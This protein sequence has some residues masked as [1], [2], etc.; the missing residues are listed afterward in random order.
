MSLPSVP[1]IAI[2]MIPLVGPATTLRARGPWIR[3]LGWV[4]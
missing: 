2:P 3:C 4:W 1:V